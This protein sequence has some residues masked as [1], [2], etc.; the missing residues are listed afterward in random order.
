M[1]EMIAVIIALMHTYIFF[2]ESIFWG[3][4]KTNKIFGVNEEHATIC[5]SLAFNQGFYNLF[6]AIGIYVGLILITSGTRP[7]EGRAFVDFSCAS[8]AGAGLV[9]ILSAKKLRRA[10]LL[11]LLPALAYF[12]TRLM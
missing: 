7:V 3:R 1:A 4:P 11:Q 12:A 9:L 2:L 10:G 8:V 6:L 5:K